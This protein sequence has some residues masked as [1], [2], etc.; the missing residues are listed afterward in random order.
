[1]MLIAGVLF[2]QSN[3]L[4]WTLTVKVK[5]DKRQEYEKKLVP[6]LKTNY[7][8]LKIRTW[9]VITGENTGA[10]VFVMGPTSYKEMD[11][12]LVSPKGEGQLKIDAQALD[13][14]SESSVAAHAVRVEAASMMK[15][16]RKMKYIQV[17]SYEIKLFTWGNYRQILV[18]SKEARTK[19]G[20]VLDYDVFRPSNSGPGN[21][22]SIVTHY[23]KLEELTM[24]EAFDEMYD[25]ANGN[26][27]YNDLTEWNSNIL[28]QRYELRVLRSDLSQL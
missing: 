4:F 18:K 6:F 11:V 22:F 14:M 28:S 25:K 7:P 10:F 27:F 13:A 26:A 23:N 16:D 3:N 5:M 17:V 24:T 9:E 21:T 1:M 19:G 12:P 8:N 15:P 2:S 20:S